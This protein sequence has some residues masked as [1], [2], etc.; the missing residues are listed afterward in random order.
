MCRDVMFNKCG[1]EH[2]TLKHVGGITA[3]NM[4]THVELA[5]VILCVGLRAMTCINK[6]V[7]DGLGRGGVV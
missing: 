1:I 4:A 6:C 3:R 7:R 5:R 2:K